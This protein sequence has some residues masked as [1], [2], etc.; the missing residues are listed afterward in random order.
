M[1]MPELV[2]VALTVAVAE[3]VRRTAK[4]LVSEVVLVPVTVP[5]LKPV[6]DWTSTGG[7]VLVLFGFFLS[8]DMVKQQNVSV[9]RKK[10]LTIM[11][12][13]DTYNQKLHS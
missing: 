11:L 12:T 6:L 3:L 7:A 9:R 4:V 5:I 8:D 10:I 13:E 1:L 2:T